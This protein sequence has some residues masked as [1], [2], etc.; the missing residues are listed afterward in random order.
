MTDFVEVVL[1]KSIT[2]NGGR[3]EKRRGRVNE[4]RRGSGHDNLGLDP[5][6]PIQ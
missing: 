2:K 4:R 3:R 5:I 6:L 1:R